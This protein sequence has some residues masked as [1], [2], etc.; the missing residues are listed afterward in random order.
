MKGKW[1]WM[2]GKGPR[3]KGFLNTRGLVW[4][5]WE[6]GKRGVKGANKGF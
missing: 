6:I 4:V 3:M 1:P 5:F 2:K